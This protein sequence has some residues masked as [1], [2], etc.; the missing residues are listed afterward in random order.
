MLQIG[1]LHT[2]DDGIAMCV[3]VCAFVRV[4]CM[5]E[6]MI[7]HG[8]T[9]ASTSS[10][11]VVFDRAGLLNWSRLSPSSSWSAHNG[12]W[13]SLPASSSSL[14]LYSRRSCCRACHG[15]WC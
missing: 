4:K 9:S 3:L 13:Q 10:R 14:Q 6:K 1:T 5:S 2:G 7:H 12:D 8:S 15:P 11:H